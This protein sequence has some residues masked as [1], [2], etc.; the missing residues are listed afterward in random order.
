MTSEN[1]MMKFP[2]PGCSHWLC[3]K[4]SREIIYRDETRYHLDPRP[5]GCPPCPNGCNNPVR[6]KQCYCEEY[7][8]V[9]DAWGSEFPVEC[10][11]W[12]DCE[13]LSIESDHTDNSYGSRKCPVCRRSW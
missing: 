5:F 10:K 6:G 9:Q 7:D 4:C 13:H 2:A 11:I 8:A 1:A 12:I 3:V